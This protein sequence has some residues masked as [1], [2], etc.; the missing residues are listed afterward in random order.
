MRFGRFLSNPKVG[1]E[2]IPAGWGERTGPAAAGRHV[3][4]IQDTS[5]IGFHT[6]EQK[7]CLGAIGKG[8][9]Q[10]LLLHAMLAADAEAGQCLGLVGGE[11]WTR[12][13]LAASDHHDRPFQEKE[14]RRWLTTAQTARTVLA[15]AARGPAMRANAHPAQRP[16]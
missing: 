4:A 14:S 11:V 12:S 3:L 13:G 8:K 7:A 15:P 2:A 9:H 10:G 5:E 6:A 16:S 1:V